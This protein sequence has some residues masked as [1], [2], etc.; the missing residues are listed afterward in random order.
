MNANVPP[1]YAPYSRL[2]P[3]RKVLERIR[4]RGLPSPITS[5]TLE[6]LGI[7]VGNAYQVLQ[8]LK[9][10][11]LIDEDGNLTV[12]YEQ[13]RQASTQEYPSVLADIIRKAYH[14]IFTIIDPA[15]D[16]ATQINDAFRKYDPPGQRDRMTWLF[17]GL[18]RM[19]GI[20]P[21]DGKVRRRAPTKSRQQVARQKPQQP[22]KNLQPP[23]PEMEIPEDISDKDEMP[24]PP[25][26]ELPKEEPPLNDDEAD[27]RLM[28]DLMRRKLPK[29]ERKWSRARRDQWM[30][31]MGANIDMVVEIIEATREE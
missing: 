30:L 6:E 2:E 18:C 23:L 10:L 16:D 12:P 8:T 25:K 9:F 15:T 29:G 1:K 13:L 21:D 3:I 24:P 5:A 17:L 20:V 19:A 11:D 28:F 4:N 14:H 22:N 31:A 27:Y 7:A 26:E